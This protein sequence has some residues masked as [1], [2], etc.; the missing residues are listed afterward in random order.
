MEAITNPEKALQKAREA[1]ELREK[2]AAKEAAANA[3]LL[4]KAGGSG[5][6]TPI[7][8]KGG[9]SQ[10]SSSTKPNTTI[11]LKKHGHHTP[12][13]GHASVAQRATSPPRTSGAPRPSTS[14]GGTSSN[15]KGG[16]KNGSRSS[17]PNAEGSSPSSTGQK[18]KSTSITT[19]G[20]SSKRAKTSSGGVGSGSS[21]PNR[22]I[23]PL[24]S[25]RASSP[26]QRY[27][28]NNIEKELIRL[29]KSGEATN[30]KA[31][32]AVFSN[33][34]KKGE[35]SKTDFMQAFKE[36]LTQ[37]PDKTLKVKDGY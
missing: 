34:L 29:V 24:A 27:P 13:A 22:A 4:S 37:G 12:G 35:I 36:V 30:I 25:P 17:S 19:G 32:L 9:P 16:S 3:K 15:S 31:C 7:E 20:D 26:I 18:R 10:S 8:E 2:E 6:A 1:K 5:A 33:K 21:S 28:S 23:S 14:S 11:T